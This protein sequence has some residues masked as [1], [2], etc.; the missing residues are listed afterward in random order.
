MI[1]RFAIAGIALGLLLFTGGVFLAEGYSAKRGFLESLP[2]MKVRLSPDVQYARFSQVLRSETAA[3]RLIEFEGRLIQMPYEMEDAEVIRVV[4][5]FDAQRLGSA[6]PE[7]Q[8]F[9]DGW[10]VKPGINF[11]LGLVL[12]VGS[13]LV[14][15]GAAVLVGAHVRNRQIISVPISDTERHTK[16]ESSEPKA[17]TKRSYLR[18]AL[19]LWGGVCLKAAADVSGLIGVVSGLIAVHGGTTIESA[20]AAALTAGLIAGLLILAGYYLSHRLVVALDNA[21]LSPK[22][23]KTLLILLPIAYFIGAIVLGGT[24]GLITGTAR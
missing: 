13:A 3:G 12:A 10:A 19:H 24:V 14:I 18:F 6:R 1:G 16:A 21:P 4:A 8:F 20:G 5:A 2:K 23:K 7:H 22:Q 17:P 11:P 9:F 15:I